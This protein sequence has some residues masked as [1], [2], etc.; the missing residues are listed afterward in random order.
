ML[1]RAV[2]LALELATLRHYNLPAVPLVLL[3]FSLLDFEEQCIWYTPNYA[4]LCGKCR[5]GS[6]EGGHVRIF[7]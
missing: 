2:A 7:F 1:M 3:E 6:V 5:D 4:N